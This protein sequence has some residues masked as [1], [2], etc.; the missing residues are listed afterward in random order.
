MFH[1]LTVSGIVN[2]LATSTGTPTSDMVRL[3][4]GD[5]TVLLEKSTLLPDNDPL[6][7]PSFPF[8]L[9]VKVF[10]GLPDR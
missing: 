8:N 3:G 9:C 2:F 4:S 5:I 7:R 1:S 6:K 10:K